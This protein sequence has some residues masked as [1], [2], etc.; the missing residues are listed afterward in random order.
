MTTFL[1]RL[2]AKLVWRGTYLWSQFLQEMVKKIVK[3]L[4]FYVTIV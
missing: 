2:D 4:P 3:L 1:P